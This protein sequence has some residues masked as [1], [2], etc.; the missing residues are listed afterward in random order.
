MLSPLINMNITLLQ[1]SNDKHHVN[2]NS[3]EDDDPLMNDFEK[4]YT[5]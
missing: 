2:V 1:T 5:Q 3:D 4:D